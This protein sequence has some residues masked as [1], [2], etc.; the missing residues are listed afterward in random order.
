VTCPAR[1]PRVAP[2]SQAADIETRTR[3]RLLE[4]A[5]REL[6]ESESNGSLLLGAADA[7]AEPIVVTAAGCSVLVAVGCRSPMLMS[8]TELRP[9]GAGGPRGLA[10]G[11]DRALR[12]VNRLPDDFVP[13]VS[14]AVPANASRF[15]GRLE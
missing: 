8:V 10:E 9:S 7:D 14:F 11:C 4:L 5:A 2:G 12:I 1:Q 15:L 3:L 13:T 6:L